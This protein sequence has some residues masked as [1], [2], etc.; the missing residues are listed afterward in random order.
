MSR[1]P[2]PTSTTPTTR[3]ATMPPHPAFSAPYY[4]TSYQYPP[5]Q[6]QQQQAPQQHGFYD[7]HESRKRSASAAEQ[8]DEDEPASAGTSAAPTPREENKSKRTKTQR[9]CDPCRRKK[10][11]CDILPDTDPPICQHCKQYSFNCTFFLP[12]TETRFKKK[13][14]EEDQGS[15]T[16]S[17]TRPNATPP[18]PSL[19]V[20]SHT[21]SHA[22]THTHPPP[23]TQNQ[24]QQQ[25]PQSKGEVK[26]YGP[27]SLSFLVHST[28]TIP[29]RTMESY[30]TRYH[31][32]WQVG[33]SGEG[34][35]QVLEPSTANQPA[36]APLP[37]PLEHRVE[38]ETLQNLINAYFREVAPTFCVITRDEFVRSPAPPPVLL[39]SMCV[40]AA[41]SR[42]V[43]RG[44]FEALRS[45]LASVMR[46]D[47]VLS[48][49]SVAN[50]Q[51]LLILSMNGD[52]H[53]VSVPNATSAAWLRAGA[54]IR[55]A[56]DLGMHRA[57]A[58][59]TDLELRRR[60]WSA[61]VVVDSWYAASYGH[62]LAINVLDCDVRLPRA[63]EAEGLKMEFMGELV[64]LSILLG[65]VLKSI[66][67]PTGLL[68]ARD[69]ILETLLAD[70]D[71]WRHQLPPQF[72]F[73]NAATA[74]THAGLLHLYY[75]CVC[76]MFWRVFT[77]ISY[78]CPAHLKFSL[79]VE[80]MTNLV[81]MSRDVIDWLSM[82]EHE[83]I[84]DCCYMVGYAA[85]AA[86][87]VQYHAWA[88]RKDP[89]AVVRLRRLKDTIKRWE[90]VVEP[91][92]MPTAEIICL[93]YEATQC[94]PE[95]SR[96]TDKR[97]NPT[98][99]VHNVRAPEALRGLEFRK[100]AS[101]PGG[102][103]FVASKRMIPALSDLPRGTVVPRPDTADG[104][105]D[106]ESVVSGMSGSEESP[107]GYGVGQQH[108]NVNPALAQVELDPSEN[109]GVQVLNMLDQP[110]PSESFAVDNEGMLS[111]I[112][113]P[114]GLQ[115]DLGANEQWNSLLSQFQPAMVGDSA[116]H[117]M[118][119]FS[120]P[121]MGAVSTGQ[122][123]A[124]NHNA[125]PN[126][127]GFPPMQ[128]FPHQ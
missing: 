21:H 109:M 3:R 23:P 100:D 43:E 98:V 10:I 50:V 48:V 124:A 101:R 46:N 122:L 32:T 119:P 70:L 30:D 125:I 107:F 87:L 38:R 91:G 51:A 29:V 86:A 80:R 19:D 35:I 41:C 39:Y 93:L 13:R 53:S 102:G 5:Q 92:H 74:G 110:L 69:S 37:K 52:C 33:A 90:A 105:R 66:Y 76:M 75:A 99:G 113:L 114:N 36:T 42:R 16:T 115:Y 28:A 2:T 96:T 61:C 85:T 47:D 55:M 67:S 20:H 58:V 27:T 88:R 108:T 81:H 111:G 128:P 8:D 72:V 64:K 1:T 17:A 78:S 25:Q 121:Y 18:T 56:Q 116:Y 65:R 79:T 57:E 82:E 22:H 9:A 40:V 60:L 106:R 112:G 12:I 118:Q 89:E 54:A 24:L 11:R 68:H 84:F 4:P 97:L 71:L 34:F 126:G 14:M 117:L 62:P 94:A 45:T 15:G 103:V 7:E 77:R 49:S 104:D 120:E 26:I 73:T 59:Q 127:I 6:Q 31:Q 44:V 123:H 83:R 63:D 95:P